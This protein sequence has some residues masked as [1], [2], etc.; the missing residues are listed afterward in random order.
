MEEK[1]ITKLEEMGTHWDYYRKRPVI[2]KAIEVKEEKVA[3]KTREGTLYGYKGDFIIQGVE[4]E[5]YPC[6]RDIFFKTYEEVKEE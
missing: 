3:I 4:G 6:G 5:I 1:I 2:I